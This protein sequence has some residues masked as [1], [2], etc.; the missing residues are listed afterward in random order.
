M[1]GHAG[2]FN[3][4]GERVTKLE[5]ALVKDEGAG[6]KRAMKLFDKN[7]ERDRA[8]LIDLEHRLQRVQGARVSHSDSKKKD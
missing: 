7:S 1:K 6:R 8:S 2:V 3:R 4:L 5:D